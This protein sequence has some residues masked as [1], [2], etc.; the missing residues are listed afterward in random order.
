ME[1]VLFSRID[2]VHEKVVEVVAWMDENKSNSWLEYG[3]IVEDDVLGRVGSLRTTSS[4]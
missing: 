4:V 1:V 2:R 3:R